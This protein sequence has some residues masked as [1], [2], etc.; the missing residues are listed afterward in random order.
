[1]EEEFGFSFSYGLVSCLCSLFICGCLVVEAAF[2]V[3]VM[4]LARVLHDN[5]K[6]S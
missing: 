4:V 2:V 6:E 5:W 3:L 1:M